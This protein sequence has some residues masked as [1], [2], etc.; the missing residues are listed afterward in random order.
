MAIAT[1]GIGLA[2]GIGKFFEGRA[3]QK[4][5]QNLINNFE[6]QDL[7]NPYENQR[8]S[9]LGSDLRTEQA[10][11]NTAST[12]DALRSGG[13][14]AI[15]G[16]LGRLQA[17]NNLLNR[18]IAANLDEQQRKI[19]FAKSAQDVRNQDMIEQRQSQEL[20][21]YGNMLGM[22]QQ[23]KFGGMTDILNT[24]GFLGQTDIGKSVDSSIGDIFKTE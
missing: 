2:G 17:Q 14:R 5:A 13:S 21:G 1:A 10:N 12:V 16:G 15:V 24:A 20:S 22:G 11:I 4:R 7:E 19:D 3:M 23:M 9:T 8:V 6:W 18:D